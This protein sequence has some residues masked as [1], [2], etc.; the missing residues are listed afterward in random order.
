MTIKITTFSEWR[1]CGERQLVA[2]IIKLWSS[3]CEVLNSLTT[4]RLVGQGLNERCQSSDF[5]K[6]HEKTCWQ[7]GNCWPVCGWISVS[8]ILTSDKLLTCLGL[9]HGDHLSRELAV[10]SYIGVNGQPVQSLCELWIEIS[11]Y[12][13]WRERYFHWRFRKW[14]HRSAICSFICYNKLSLWFECETP[15]CHFGRPSIQPRCQLLCM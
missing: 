7:L 9:N 3:I 6:Y 4:P 13:W 14:L 15:W 10:P 8:N 12:N 1:V 11:T 2:D 5:V